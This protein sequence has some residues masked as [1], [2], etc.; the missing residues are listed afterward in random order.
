MGLDMYLMGRRSLRYGPNAQ[1]AGSAIESL[2]PELEH[3]PSHWGSDTHKISEITVDLGYWR[4]ANAIHRWFVENCQDGRDDCGTYNVSRDKLVALLELCQ[5]VVGFR[6]LA[7][8]QLPT[9]E[10]FFFGSTG[11]GDSYY[12]DL[13]DTIGIIERCLELPPEWSFEYHSSW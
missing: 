9:L 10:G 2:F 1:S 11:Y 3:I 7:E 6:H 5:R 4:K 8:E 12:R 13:E